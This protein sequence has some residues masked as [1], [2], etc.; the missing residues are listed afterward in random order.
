MKTYSSIIVVLFLL[1]SFYRNVDPVKNGK[2]IHFEISRYNLLFT[3]VEIND[4]E[5]T[6]LIDFGD[7]AA[8]QLSTTVIEELGL[9]TEK[10]DILMTD[11]N[12]NTY[13]L[14]KGQL[15]ELKVDGIIEKEITFFSAKNEIETVSEQVGTEFQVAIGI[16]YFKSKSFKL[17]FVNKI[18]EFY[19]SDT[20]DKEIFTTTMNTDYGYLIG[21]FESITD[22][23]IHLLFDTGAPIS[24]IDIN[25]LNTDLKDSTVSFQGFNFPTK[26]LHLKSEAQSISLNMEDGSLSEL[27]PLN[28]KGIYGVNDMKGK[29]F[30]FNTEDQ[31]VG[32]KT[33]GSPEQD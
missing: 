13:A 8:F 24:K 5:Y 9:E 31:I 21:Q 33:T 1:I 19:D 15:N 23:T 12:G 11:V 3:T 2:V 25:Q 10:S 26:I 17:D 30:Y 32:I 28:V 7:F 18:I 22:D 4:K 20:P 29:I 27:E 16:G 6:A 14:E